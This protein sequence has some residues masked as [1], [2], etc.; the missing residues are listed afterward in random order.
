[1][2]PPDGRGSLSL[3]ETNNNHY[4]FE[5][6]NIAQY[7]HLSNML[8]NIAESSIQKVAKYSTII[9]SIYVILLLDLKQ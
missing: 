1:M 8:Q 4:G 2:K 9:Y 7:K 5:L 3:Q 6:Q